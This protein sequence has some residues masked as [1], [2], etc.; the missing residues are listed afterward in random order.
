MSLL[1]A[2]SDAVLGLCGEYEEK[3]RVRLMKCFG[4]RLTYC[5]RRNTG[6][7]GLLVSQN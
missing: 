7:D 6:N 1:C 3:L 4:A 2:S 5:G